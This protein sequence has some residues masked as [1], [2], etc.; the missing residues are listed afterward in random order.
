MRGVKS[1]SERRSSWRR[2]KTAPDSRPS[3]CANA[4]A[5]RGLAKL[6]GEEP[7]HRLTCPLAEP[8][9]AERIG[10]DPKLASPLE[11]LAG[12]ELMEPEHLELGAEVLREKVFSVVERQPDVGDK[13]PRDVADGDRQEALEETCIRVPDPE[14]LERSCGDPELIEQGVARVAFGEHK[15]ERLVPVAGHLDWFRLFP[16]SGMSN[17]PARSSPAFWSVMRSWSATKSRTSP[18]RLQEQQHQTTRS[19]CTV[20]D[21]LFTSLKGQQQTS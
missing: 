19:R 2:S 16:I 5:V 21:S 3:R 14:R 20:N 13:H 17:H 1:L 18:P 11:E 6:R 7:H 4:R 15:A 10:R 12:E 8:D 9:G